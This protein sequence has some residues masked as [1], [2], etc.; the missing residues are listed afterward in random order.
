LGLALVL[1]AIYLVVVADIH[2]VM[3]MKGVIIITAVTGCGLV[4][5]L[6]SKIILTLWL[7]TKKKD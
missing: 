4:L 2:N 3:G 1:F 5:L 7:M 6:P